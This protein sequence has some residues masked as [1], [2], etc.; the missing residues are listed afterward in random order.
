[1]VTAASSDGFDGWLWEDRTFCDTE[2]LSHPLSCYFEPSC[3]RNESVSKTW[4]APH[5]SVFPECVHPKAHVNE[6]GMEILFSRLTRRVLASAENAAEEVFGSE[7]APPNLISVHLRWGDKGKE[8]ELLPVSKY[9]EAVE[10]L[11]LKVRLSPS[12]GFASKAQIT[13]ALCLLQF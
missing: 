11:V 13:T 3:R 8:M 9:V 4:H 10:S 6:A 1:M 5:S 7:G 12:T 2:D